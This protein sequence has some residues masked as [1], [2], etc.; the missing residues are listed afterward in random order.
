MDNKAFQ[1][2]DKLWNK[3]DKTPKEQRMLN[4]LIDWF[5]EETVANIPDDY[6]EFI[7]KVKKD[8]QK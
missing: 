1:L 3:T 7:Q 4:K 5:A 2:M 6:E 8:T